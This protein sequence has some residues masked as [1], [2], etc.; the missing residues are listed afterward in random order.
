MRWMM[1][2][3]AIHRDANGNIK[4]NK[5]KAVE[6]VDGAVSMVMAWGQYMTY[7]VE[8]SFASYLEDPDADVLMF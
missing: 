3:V 5:A 6:K 7:K 2:N 1:G 8:P 4:I